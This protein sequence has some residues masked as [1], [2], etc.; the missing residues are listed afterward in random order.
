M[1]FDDGPNLLTKK[2][3]EFFDRKKVKVT[4]FFL[5]NRLKDPKLL[6]IVKLALKKGH[7]IGNHNYYHDNVIDKIKKV[8]QIEVLKYMK[9]ST[10]LFY[11]KLGKAPK[12]FRP[13]YGEL[14]DELAILIKNLNF[15]IA[16]W[17]LDT[18]DWYWEKKGRDKLNIVKS[19]IEA[20][21]KSK[22]TGKPF[23]SLQHEKSNNSEAEYERLNYIIDLIR[24]YGYKIV[25]LH[26]CLN[27]KNPYFNK[28]ELAVFDLKNSCK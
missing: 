12:Y 5:A 11:Q 6:K 13:P 25:P 18:K 9:K 3:L 17:N 8:N 15:K 24:M 21:D 22:C 16:Y 1:T 28:E 23:I 20:L 19:F 7:Q 4:F 14:N 2:H 10:E 27:D 26:E